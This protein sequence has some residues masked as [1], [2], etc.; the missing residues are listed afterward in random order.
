M[1]S[2]RP[3]TLCKNMPPGP[4]E[5]PTSANARFNPLRLRL[6]SRISTVPIIL[7]QLLHFIVTGLNTGLDHRIAPSGQITRY[8][9]G[10]LLLHSRPH[11]PAIVRMNLLNQVR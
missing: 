9:S 8:C 7:I 4:F 2:D 3:Q 6:R 5:P 1:I 11:A 10:I